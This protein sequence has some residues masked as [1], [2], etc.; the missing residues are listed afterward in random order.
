M[1]NYVNE[2]HHN[3]RVEFDERRLGLHF[4][5]HLLL[6]SVE[7]WY[8]NQVIQKFASKEYDLTKLME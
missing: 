3:V 6:V 7:M 4:K 1:K 5:K 2:S 8:G